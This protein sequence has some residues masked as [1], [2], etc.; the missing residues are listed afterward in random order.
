MWG[1]RL[2]DT[3]WQEIVDLKTVGYQWFRVLAK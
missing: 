1:V 3:L 2:E